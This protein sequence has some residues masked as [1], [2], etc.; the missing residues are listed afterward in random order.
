MTDNS[1]SFQIPDKGIYFLSLGGIGEIGANCYL[2]CC[3]GKWIM[4]DLGITFADEKYPGVDIL[5]PKIDFLENIYKQIEAIIISHGHEDHAG[6]VAYLADKINCPV[7]ATS[8]AKIL[9]ENRLKEFG[10]LDKVKLI[11]IDTKKNIDLNKFSIEFISTTHSIPESYSIVINTPYGKLLHTAD[12]KIDDDPI[13]GENFN[14]D[15]FKNLG[16]EGILALIGDSTNADV[17]G[18]SKSEKEV[19]KELTK[20]FSRYNQRIVA[21]C[22]SSNIARIESIALAAKKN[23]RKVVL[24]GRSMKKTIDAAVQTGFIKDISNFIDEEEASYIPRGNLVIICTGSQGEKK[25]ALYRI[26]YNAHKNIHLENGDL[27]I[28]SSRDIPGNEKSINN[29]KN[30]LIRQRIE[31][32]TSEDD[33]VHV[34]GHGYAEE[35]KTMYNWVRPYIAI[36]VHGEPKHLVAHSKLA[37]SCQV[38]FTKILENG[39]CIKLAPNEPEIYGKVETGKMIVEGRNLYDSESAFIKD[40]RKYSFEGLVL[41]SLIIYEDF[42]IDKNIKISF[43]GLSDHDSEN[44]VNLFKEKFINDYLSM[45]N[46]KK[47]SDLIVSELIKKVI[48]QIIKEDLRKKPEIK[49]HIIRL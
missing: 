19:R 8:F 13:I 11:S 30:L 38:P 48:R 47:S 34:S 41:I 20:L 31:I 33:L 49:S 4:I 43:N 1:E 16:N 36:P 9:I 23:N 44:T 28:F 14:F 29:L 7:Y 25:S 27:V 18:S 22:F 32:I 10:K 2:Y 37:Q 42:S 17:P 35:I 26:S 24:V 3:D 46:E 39:K 5:V 45:N 15:S 6:A 40:R 12:W 21:T